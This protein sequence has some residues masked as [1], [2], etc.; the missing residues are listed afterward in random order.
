MGMM[1]IVNTTSE[2]G[3]NGIIVPISDNEMDD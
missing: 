3:C 1:K 2:H